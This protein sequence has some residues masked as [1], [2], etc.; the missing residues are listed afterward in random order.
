MA[1]CHDARI[2]V[3]KTGCSEY[4]CRPAVTHG[5]KLLHSSFVQLVL[6]RSAFTCTVP[7]QLPPASF[8]TLTK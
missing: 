2:A 8:W 7:P 5:H 3:E 1:C 4:D 6:T